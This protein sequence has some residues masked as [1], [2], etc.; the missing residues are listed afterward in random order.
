[1]V[2]YNLT[3]IVKNELVLSYGDFTGIS[4]F[5]FRLRFGDCVDGK[6]KKFSSKSKITGNI[7]CYFIMRYCNEMLIIR[8][9]Y[10]DPTAFVDFSLRQRPAVEFILKVIGLK[11]VCY[12]VQHCSGGMP[13]NQVIIP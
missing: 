2:S 4:L 11:A 7:A 12:L 5:L 13:A 10:K 8:I 6:H 9:L 3:K 1:M